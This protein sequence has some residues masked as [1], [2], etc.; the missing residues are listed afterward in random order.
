MSSFT[1]ESRRLA[2]ETPL[3][4]DVLLLTGFSGTEEMSRLFT[5]QLE[6]LS[7]R[8]SITAKE[9]V[10]KNVSWH[11]MMPDDTERLF[12][13][14]VRKF[15][16]LGLNDRFTAY[17][18]EVV[19]WFW[20]LTRNLD[21]RIFQ[22]KSVV[23]IIEALFRDAG[24]SDFETSEISGAHPK[25]DYCVQ[26]RES[27][28]SF[29]SRLMEQEGIFYYFRHANGKHIMVLGDQ[30]RAYKNAVENEINFDA[31]VGAPDITDQ[32]TGWQHQYEFRA[33]KCA[34]TD[35][36]F[37]TPHTN[38]LAS[39]NTVIKVDG[40][41]KFEIFDFPGDYEKKGDGE[42]DV[43]VRMEEEEVEHDV[44][45]GAGR[46]RT[47]GP[48]LKF[49]IKKHH[50][51]AE[52]GKGFVLTR[53][54][55]AATVGGSYVSGT[56][57][58]EQIYSNR[59]TC[60]PEAV[61]FRPARITPRPVVSGAQTAMVVGPSGEEIYT[62]KY[63][64]VKLQF[65]W[66]RYGKANEKSSCWVRVAQVWAGKNWGS[67]FIPRLGQEV[68]VEFLEGDPDR[69]L[70]TGR[71]YNGDCMPPY[72]LPTHA[73]MSTVKSLSSKGGDGFNELRFED[74]KGE[75]QIFIHGEKNQDVRIKNDCFEWI[76]HD[77]HLIVKNDQIE[78]VEHNRQEIVDNDHAEKI[79]NDRNLKVVGK[80]AK[81]IGASQSL[82]VKG[83]VIEVFK[84][85]HSEQTSQD[86]FLKATNIVIEAST[87]V[88]IKVGQ[89]YIAIEAGGIKIG[90]MG[91]LEFE[92]MGPLSLK[93]KAQ[94]EIEAPQTSVQGQAMLTLKGGIVMIN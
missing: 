4:K 56:G 14:F 93:S 91:T 8:P 90:T 73:T 71:V 81:D 76:G 2:I 65:H 43:K 28:F 6:M 26:Y 18:A 86:Y 33:G 88:T 25:W 15:T 9:I 94:V 37:E 51:A 79:G 5:F 57:D 70:V 64:R 83:D 59:F 20:F 61:V 84:A 3:G 42:T 11:I 1:Q 74:K 40:V 13:G 69:P 12:N 68:V 49:K 30:K 32:I 44:V 46:C 34:H 77:R 67:M 22:N 50:C 24:F 55:H 16:Y 47:F 78:H 35:Y 92:S 23:E 52:E 21:C 89:S 82:V 36:N 45:S 10:G 19:P 48:G 60:I 31:V 58:G 53:V 87:N 63:G 75:E 72:D 7:E 27:D 66:D 39:T 85:N 41:D 80:E 38:L 62:D 54:E 29:A 17:S